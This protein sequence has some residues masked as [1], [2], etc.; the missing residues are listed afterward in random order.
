MPHYFSEQQE[1]PFEP[2]E[3]PIRLKDM[4]LRLLSASG[5]FSLKRLDKGTEALLTYCA[6]PEKGADGQDARVLDL[7]CGYGVVGIVLKL[8]HPGLDL[9]Q[10]DVNA[11]ALKL[12]RMNIKKLK[13]KASVK[14]SDLFVRLPDEQFDLILTNPPYVAGR[15]LIFKLIEQAPSYLRPGGSL[16]LVARHQKGGKALEAKMR[17]VFGNVEVLGKMAGFRVYHSQ[18]GQ[19]TN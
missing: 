11:R 17:E 1:G 4:E 6:V 3:I 13:I 19:D 2:F 12:T 14:K 8:R 16:Q 15:K 7:G 5:V 18:K 9:V 10:T